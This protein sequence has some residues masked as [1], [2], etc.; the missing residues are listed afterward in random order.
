MTQS[1]HQFQSAEQ[2]QLQSYR[3]IC[4]TAVAAF[5]LGLLCPVSFIHYLLWGVPLC[6]LMLS[7]LA[8]RQINQRKGELSGATLAW[9]A[10]MLALL[11]GT[12]A[13]TQHFTR[14]ALLK[15]Q[16][17]AFADQWLSL[18][19]EHQLELA[20]Q[21]HKAPHQRKHQGAP[22]ISL[23]EENELLR[24]DKKAFYEKEPLKSLSTT[25]FQF[26][27]VRCLGVNSTFK[28]D[29]IL[30][31][32]DIIGH[33]SKTYQIQVQLNRQEEPLQGR[34]PLVGCSGTGNCRISIL[35]L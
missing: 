11:F 14:Q 28:Q 30:L 35:F 22:L 5:V 31:L 16:A 13:P 32:Y 20:H 33:D 12:W 15:T 9:I 17:E 27:F 25:P 34:S 4:L 2:E 24:E 21:L 8:L 19:Q 18:L 23:Y 3:V 29:A 1:A 7:A 26:S 6:T 10:L